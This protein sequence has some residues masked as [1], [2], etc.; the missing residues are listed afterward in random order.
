MNIIITGVCGVIGSRLHNILTKNYPKATVW[1]YDKKLNDN[2]DLSTFEGLLLLDNLA[3]SIVDVDDN[4]AV[5]ILVHLAESKGSSISKEQADTNIQALEHAIQVA[6]SS[7]V[8]RFVYVS[9]CIYTTANNPYYEAKQKAE[10][11]LQE[12]GLEYTV[13]RS[14]TL[15]D[16][17]TYQDIG[18]STLLT[19][20]LQASS[21]GSPFTQ[22][23]NPMVT[24]TRLSNFL[25]L[26]VQALFEPKYRNV[27][28]QPIGD[29]RLDLSTFVKVIIQ[30][31]VS[32]MVNPYFVKFPVV[33]ERI[34]DIDRRL[35]IPLKPSNVGYLVS[36]LSAMQLYYVEAKRKEAQESTVDEV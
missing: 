2:A 11:L 10:N 22:Y 33:Q 19:N 23:G 24:F 29:I 8:K 25:S 15:L 5:D 13:V 21:Q 7:N 14:N 18:T 28:M 16:D 1:G 34:K 3:K 26:L 9:T 30:V 20:I 6:K 32:R 27:T 36:V 4:P 12:S 35:G 17:V 31:F